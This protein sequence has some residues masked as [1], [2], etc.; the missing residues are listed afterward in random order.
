MTS[1]IFKAER[2]WVTRVE[3][4]TAIETG[5]AIIGVNAGGENGFDFDTK[6]VDPGCPDECVVGVAEEFR[7]FARSLMKLTVLGWANQLDDRMSKV[8][9]IVRQYLDR[10]AVVL[11]MRDAIQKEAMGCPA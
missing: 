11:K 3:L 1:G 9:Q 6:T 5:K 8:K 4:L 2:D 10:D 7:P